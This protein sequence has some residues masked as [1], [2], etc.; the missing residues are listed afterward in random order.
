MSARSEYE[1]ARL[2]RI[3]QNEAEMARLGLSA[4]VA[5]AA[6]SVKDVIRRDK[7]TKRKRSGADSDFSDPGSADNNSSD[8]EVLRRTGPP[9]L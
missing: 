4:A 1:E 9:S 3:R 6:D 8:S 2:A 7:T 5:S